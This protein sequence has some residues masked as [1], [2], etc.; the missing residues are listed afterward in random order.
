MNLYEKEL[1]TD[2]NLKNQIGT[3][4]SSTLKNFLSKV[5]QKG[6]KTNKKKKR[7]KKLWLLYHNKTG[8]TTRKVEKGS[9]HKTHQEC[10]TQRHV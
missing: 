8:I 9:K 6:V 1:K 7:K 10:C 3:Y 2:V 5:D 4:E